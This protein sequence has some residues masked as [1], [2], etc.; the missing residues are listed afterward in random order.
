[1]NREI[2]FR[3]ITFKGDFVYGSLSWDLGKG[4][5]FNEQQW[6]R[7]NITENRGKADLT[8]Y[9]KETRARISWYED[10]FYCN[11]PVKEETVGQFT[12][13]KDKNGKEIYEGDILCDNK[14]EDGEVQ[15]FT[16]IASFMVNTPEGVYNLNEGNISKE[17]T[18]KYTEIIGNIHEGVK[19]ER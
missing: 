10:G 7:Q 6:I 15:Y 12:G 4:L 19:N 1:M 18:L 8:A 16:S 3:G 5:S 11:A 14:G 17:Y 13:L 9:W 2:K